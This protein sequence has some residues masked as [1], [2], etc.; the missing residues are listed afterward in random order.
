MGNAEKLRAVLIR[1]RKKTASA[2]L[3]SMFKCAVGGTVPKPVTP[4]NPAAAAYGGV[5]AS[6]PSR[7]GLMAKRPAALPA[8]R[9]ATPQPGLAARTPVRVQPRAPINNNYPTIGA[10]GTPP[11]QLSPLQQ[12]AAR[13][14]DPAADQQAALINKYRKDPT[15]LM[16]AKGL[17]RGDLTQQE[18][19]A[20]I[21]Q[22]PA[23]KTYEMGGPTWSPFY[24]KRIPVPTRAVFAAGQ[25]M[26]A[27]N[28]LFGGAYRE[29]T[30]KAFGGG[31]EAGETAR[32]MFNAAGLHAA[33]AVEGRDPVALQHAFQQMAPSVPEANRGKLLNIAET[34]GTAVQP[35]RERRQ[36][37]PLF[38]A[39]I[40]DTAAGMADSAWTM[41]TPGAARN[42]PG[43]VGSALKAR[44]IPKIPFTARKFSGG[45]VQ[46]TAPNSLQRLSQ[47]NAS[48][49]LAGAAQRISA[50][51]D[52]VIAPTLRETSDLYS[53]PALGV[54]RVTP[55]TPEE[56]AALAG[57][58]A[59]A[60]A[61]QEMP[62]VTL[63]DGRPI[64]ETGQSARPFR[65]SA[66]SVENQPILDA[67]G[68]PT[69]QTRQVYKVTVQDDQ[70]EMQIND[71][72]VEV[73]DSI[74]LTPYLANKAEMPDMGKL[75]QQA[76]ETVSR[77]PLAGDMK[78]SLNTTGQAPPE[79]TDLANKSLKAQGIEDSQIKSLMDW[80]GEP[81][82][83]ATALGIGASAIG[84][85][86]MFMG[87]QDGLMGWLLPALGVTMTAG[88]L[89]A[90]GYQG[91][92]GKDVQN[93]IQ[94]VANPAMRQ[95][96][97]IAYDAG[98]LDNN[99]F[100]GQAAK[101]LSPE[102]LQKLTGS[103]G[104]VNKKI[105]EEMNK[106]LLNKA[107][108]MVYRPTAES[109]SDEQI[110]EGLKA[111]DPEAYKAFMQ[112][113]S[114][115]AKADIF[116]HWRGL[117]ELPLGQLAAASQAQSGNTYVPPSYGA[118]PIEYR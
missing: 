47:A 93:A 108:G 17:Q 57:S 94:G 67:Q 15:G 3:Y 2:R 39:A 12:A 79:T 64:S 19:D 60:A 62:A 23:W 117:E 101:E 70:G 92:F 26:N 97:G 32:K 58:A 45:R 103:F 55:K 50:Y 113:P 24:G 90:L 11:P 89:G 73:A 44:G 83:M 74:G 36:Q 37:D 1:Q 43:V 77:N 87:G 54:K 116:K 14:R 52:E 42:I 96:G 56:Y 100:W 84:L 85:L 72:P 51:G 48:P 86:M 6:A 33:A 69:G 114:A 78:T 53:N 59:P 4:Q 106:S 29:L 102:L 13:P 75:N 30:N 27:L 107:I 80:W 76:A 111:Q 31:T 68:K 22:T 49:G 95:L 40:E 66:N 34:Y 98:W 65:L 38:N 25:G 18:F 35:E 10:P 105:D 7:A 81:G 118:Q 41:A 20:A 99:Q 21:K 63:P 112:I 8:A 5:N 28:S 91:T 46:A 9:P 104:S 71:V 82:N 61:P 109:I 115:K 16:L 110:L 88:G